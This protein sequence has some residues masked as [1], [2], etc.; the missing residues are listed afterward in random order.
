MNG[1]ASVIGISATIACVATGAARAQPA[2]SAA[3]ASASGP[4]AQISVIGATESSALAARPARL[5]GVRTLPDGTLEASV[6]WMP[7]NG[8]QPVEQGMSRIELLSPGDPEPAGEDGPWRTAFAIVSSAQGELW[9]R[10]AAPHAIRSGAG[11]QDK[12]LPGEGWL[13]TTDGQRL[14]GRIGEGSDGAAEALSWQSSRFGL[15]SAPLDDV[16]ACVFSDHVPS[17]STDGLTSDR[18]LLVNGDVIDGFL[19]SIASDVVFERKGESEADRVGLDRVA[20]ILMSAE[21]VPALGAR[22][23]LGDGSV[24]RIRSARDVRDQASGVIASDVEVS[25]RGGTVGENAGGTSRG[26]IQMGEV[27]ALTGDAA[28]LVPLSGLE[29]VSQ[30]AHE[31][32]SS[33]AGL[34]VAHSGGVLGSGDIVLPGPMTV[35]WRLPAGAMAI[36][37][38]IELAA[39]CEVWGD[40]DVEVLCGEQRVARGRIRASESLVIGASVS[41]GET[42]R[43]V[44]EPGAHGS[45]QDVVVIRDV[46]IRSRKE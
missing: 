22:M 39:G 26:E 6:R 4:G 3:G 17:L 34:I 2:S 14:R 30:S 11:G 41:C 19:V 38:V 40:C 7:T 25:L 31:S 45:I 12:H 27:R 36:A 23:W 43:V 33:S 44:V 8:T 10:N 29:V 18:M 15:L 37:G 46:V 20:T 21:H 9:A 13:L 35:E 28:R 24:V 32:R 42:L 5:H 16:L 1:I